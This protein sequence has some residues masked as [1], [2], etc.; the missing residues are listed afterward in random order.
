MERKLE[1]K[2]IAG[3]LPYELKVIEYVFSEIHTIKLDIIKNLFLD[4]VKPILRPLPD[5][6]KEIT[7]NG[8]E[9]FIPI[10]ELAKIAFPNI[11]W[12][13]ASGMC[14]NENL[15]AFE[16]DEGYFYSECRNVKNIAVHSQYQLFDKL[17]EWKIDYRGLID[18][19]LAVSVYDLS[20]NP[21]K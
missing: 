16:F 9:Q 17:H 12:K 14:V 18:A 8:S 20:E 1:L 7:N 15:E 13:L 21:Y 11:K 5:L 3:Y 10:V 2:D 19:C 6:Y 4:R